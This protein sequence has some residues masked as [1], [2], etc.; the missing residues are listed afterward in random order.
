[1]SFWGNYH[2][3]TVGTT[4][5]TGSSHIQEGMPIWEKTVFVPYAYCYRC[6]LEKS[7]PNCDMACLRYIENMFKSEIS[8]IYN[9][10]T[11][12]NQVSVMFY[13]PIQAHLG[14]IIPP[15][16]YFKGIRKICDEYGIV[17]V[18]DEVAMGFGHTGHWFACEYYDVVPDIIGMAKA[19]TGGVWPLGA[20]I[21]KKEIMDVWGAESDKHMGSYHGNPVG[22]AV[23]LENIRLIKERN[24]LHN[25]KN[26]GKYM[27]EGIKD[28]K[29]QHKIIGEVVGVGLVLGAELVRDQKT[30]EPAAKETQELVLECMKRGV[31]ILRL[32]PYGNRL[33]M[34]PSLNTSKDEAD[35]ILRVLDESLTIVERK[36][37]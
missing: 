14:M 25:A 4:S 11:R 34:M 24:L 2:G 28:L 13:E 22:C 5:V 23:A 36:V 10:S 20:I 3:R 31:L 37:T 26:I 30:K 16:E 35:T 29:K 8:V 1:M 12:N 21:A 9:P 33:N 32:G 17:L 7:Y 15:I 18:D 27:L 19:M 6:F